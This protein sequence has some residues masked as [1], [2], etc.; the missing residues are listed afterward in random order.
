VRC[1]S[2]HY[3]NEEFYLTIHGCSKV[4]LRFLVGSAL[5]TLGLVALPAVAAAENVYGVSVSEGSTASGFS[6][7]DTSG[8]AEATPAHEARVAIT[9][10]GVRVAETP[11]GQ[12]SFPFMTQVPQAG[13]VLTLESPPGTTVSSLTYDGLPTMDATVCGGSAN[14]SGQRS[15]GTTLTGRYSTESYGGPE[16]FVEVPLSS[17]SAFATS[18]PA[19]LKS[20]ETVFAEEERESALAGGA[21]FVY[22]SSN[23]RPVG[24]CAAPAQPAAAAPVVVPLAPVLLP[25][26]GGTVLKLSHTTIAKLLKSGWLVQVSINQPGTVIQDLY[27]V[28]GKLPAFASRKHPAVR[29]QPPALLVARGASTVKKA[30][31]VKVLVR[32]TAHGR[33]ALKHTKSVKLVLITTLRSTSGRRIDLGRHSI[34]LKS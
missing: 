7:A 19:A 26:L 1:R 31:T 24:A 27:M 30:G 16:G 11:S 14:F 17:A 34:T 21:S 28:S 8:F 12:G 33:R 3:E 29:K 22:Y 13:D 15:P 9:R 6:V 4:A 23:V 32:V 18:F 20:G 10:A 5:L 25:L 2:A